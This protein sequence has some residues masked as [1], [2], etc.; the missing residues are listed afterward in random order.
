MIAR[1]RAILPTRCAAMSGRVG[2]APV[3]R[4]AVFDAAALARCPPYEIARYHSNSGNALL[5]SGY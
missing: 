2:N 1:S 3:R 5:A 4:A